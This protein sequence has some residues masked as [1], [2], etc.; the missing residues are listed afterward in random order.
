MAQRE[1]FFLF[2]LLFFLFSFS[3]YFQ[4]QLKIPNFHL[5]SQ[6]LKCNKH[7]Y[8]H[9]EISILPIKAARGRLPPLVLP[10]INLHRPSISSNLHRSSVCLVPRLI[11]QHPTSHVG[12]CAPTPRLTGSPAPAQA[13]L[14]RPPGKSRSPTARHGPPRREAPPH[15]GF[16]LLPTCRLRHGSPA[17]RGC[18]PALRL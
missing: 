17:R 18:L 3:F 13:A 11:R 2:L 7:K 14:A 16:E 10:S 9:A 15:A 6:Q 8:Q 1:V 4:I 12:S 5:C